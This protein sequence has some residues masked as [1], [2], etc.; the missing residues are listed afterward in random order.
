MTLEKKAC[1][2]FALFSQNRVDPKKLDSEELMRSLILAR[3]HGRML[4][5]KPSLHLCSRTHTKTPHLSVGSSV[6][7]AAAAGCPGFWL[8]LHRGKD[9]A[10]RQLYRRPVERKKRPNNLLS[11]VWHAGVLCLHVVCV[12]IFN[13]DLV[14]LVFCFVFLNHSCEK[15][16]FMLC[17]HECANQLAHY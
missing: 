14:C 6:P 17:K 3:F 10:C 4:C 16:A 2:C 1:I 15:Y 9:G 5:K 12:I 13:A 8:Q 11:L 7:A